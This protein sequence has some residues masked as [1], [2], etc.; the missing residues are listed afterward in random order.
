[1]LKKVYSAVLSIK[2]T[3]DNFFKAEYNI[4][5]SALEDYISGEMLMYGF[6]TAMVESM[7]TGEIILQLENTDGVLA[8]ELLS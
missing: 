6:S 4:E 2:V 8:D 3:F 7:D 5:Y 1:M